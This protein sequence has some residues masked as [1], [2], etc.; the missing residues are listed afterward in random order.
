MRRS[1]FVHEQE[2]ANAPVRHPESSWQQLLLPSSPRSSRISQRGASVLE[3]C[4]AVALV[5]LA[6]VAA[7]ST[8]GGS[9]SD[10]ILHGI[11]PALGGPQSLQVA[12]AGSAGGG[13]YGDAEPD[14]GSVGGV[15]GG[16]PDD[17][18]DTGSVGGGDASPPDW[19]PDTGGVGG[20]SGG[21]DPG[22]GDGAPDPG[23]GGIYGPPPE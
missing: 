16:G 21:T 18:G 14:T 4:L 2:P 15:G 9:L 1:L 8:F 20:T 3:S 5:G 12:G 23:V 19:E 17:L 13:D 22:N 10:Q 11:V 6:V 7:A